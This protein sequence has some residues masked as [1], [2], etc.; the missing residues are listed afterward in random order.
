MWG[1]QLSL[2]QR[3]RCEGGPWRHK[4]PC[5]LGVAPLSLHTT[6]P[7]LGPGTRGPAA[8]A[9]VLKRRHRGWAH[10]S[11]PP[12]AM[13]PRVSKPTAAGTRHT[14]QVCRVSNAGRGR[15]DG[16]QPQSVGGACQGA[17][18]RVQPSGTRIKGC[19]VVCMG[20]GGRGG[21]SRAVTLACRGWRGK[22]ARWGWACLF[23]AHGATLT[24]EGIHCPGHQYVVAT[25]MHA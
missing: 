8:V 13:A 9:V 16:G 17:W 11:L 12:G 24:S 22:E 5:G 4:F 19:E 20:D 6:A 10:T 23:G 15:R 7:G 18:S 14:A 21:G 2:R 3:A 25:C 1:L